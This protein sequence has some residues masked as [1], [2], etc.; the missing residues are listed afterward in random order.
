MVAF[1]RTEVDPELLPAI[2][3]RIRKAQE[4]ALA[5]AGEGLPRSTA[6]GEQV[7]D[8]A[9]KDHQL[10]VRSSVSVPEITI[11]DPLEKYWASSCR[12][13]YVTMLGA[14]LLTQI[15]MSWFPEWRLNH[16]LLGLALLVLAY[17]V[18]VSALKFLFRL[19]AEL[20][21]IRFST[22]NA[23]AL[24]KARMSTGIA[25]WISIFTTIFML[26]IALTHY[27]VARD[28]IIV[29]TPFYIVCPILLLLLVTSIGL[30]L[31]VLILSIATAKH[32]ERS[33][34]LNHP[35]PL[36]AVENLRTRMWKYEVMSNRRDRDLTPG[37]RRAIQTATEQVADELVSEHILTPELAQRLKAPTWWECRVLCTTPEFT[38][39]A[40]FPTSHNVQKSPKR[41]R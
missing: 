33:E 31:T 25:L 35:L 16:W 4:D 22:T 21:W 6:L 15:T 29:L 20:P 18:F 19:R 34:T 39:G 10:L 17:P 28:R 8:E 26:L 32:L 14:G 2:Q 38:P 24:R 41:Y 1:S 36:D 40:T 37:A 5:Y 3:L 9:N 30:W 23:R 12:L 27:S 13:L 7:F 11:S